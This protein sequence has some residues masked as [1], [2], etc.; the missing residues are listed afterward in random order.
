[1]PSSESAPDAEVDAR[2]RELA[3]IF[4]GAILRLARFSQSR[5]RE[6]RTRNAA[7][8]LVLAVLSVTTFCTFMREFSP[9]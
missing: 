4:A 2:L 6:R 7:V 9:F 8:R 1:V 3:E 5:R